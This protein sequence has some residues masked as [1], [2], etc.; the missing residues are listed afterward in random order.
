MTE[1]IPPQV[2]LSADQL[3]QLL[4]ATRKRLKLS[5]GHIGQRLNLSQNRVSYL[6][7]HPDDLSL[8]QLMN[9]CA[10]LNLELRLGAKDTG[11][12]QGPQGQ[13]W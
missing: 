3:G 1:P 6:E 4:R 9:W 7:L 2:L 13:E 8:K 5:Q 11:L 10:A 12:H